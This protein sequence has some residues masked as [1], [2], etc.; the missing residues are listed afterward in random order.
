MRTFGGLGNSQCCSVKLCVHPCEREVSVN[1]S[2]S[3]PSIAVKHSSV[4]SSARSFCCLATLPVHF[5]TYCY[6]DSLCHMLWEAEVGFLSFLI[7]QENSKTVQMNA[8][9]L[10]YS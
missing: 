4:F 9:Q 8:H 2:S 10:R 3:A 1:V 6:S 5:S 7:R